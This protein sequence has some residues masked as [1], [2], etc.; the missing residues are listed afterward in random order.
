MNRPQLNAFALRGAKLRRDLYGLAFTC[1]GASFCGSFAAITSQRQLE[2]GGWN[3]SIDST[4]RVIRSDYPAFRPHLGGILTV[5]ETG[6]AYEI[7]EIH[8]NSRSPEWV[9]GLINPQAGS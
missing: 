5:D 7:S 1:A 6:V 3:K 4:L 9:L 8:D 2:S